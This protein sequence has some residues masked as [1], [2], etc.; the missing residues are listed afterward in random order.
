MSAKMRKETIVGSFVV[1]RSCWTK[2]EMAVV[3]TKKAT[4]R[5]VCEAKKLAMVAKLG[6]AKKLPRMPKGESE[7]TFRPLNLESG[8]NGHQ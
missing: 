5:E 6:S 1:K 2:V 3:K 4:T 8:E 7:E